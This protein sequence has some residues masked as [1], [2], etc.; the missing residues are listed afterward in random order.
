M[1]GAGHMVRF[2]PRDQQFYDYFRE[3]AENALEVAGSLSD[4]LLD[5]VDAPS[6][7]R[8]IEELEH[9]GDDISHRL[10]AALNVT[11]LTPLDRG[12]ILDL[13][14]KL[15]DF[16]DL[17]TAAAVR[18]RLYNIEQPTEHAQLLGRIIAEQGIAVC[19]AISRLGND[20]Q[21]REI[22]TY[23]VEINRLE[24]EADDA[25]NRALAGLYDGAVSIPDVVN[26]MRWDELYRRLEDAAD[27]GEDLANTIEAILRK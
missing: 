4:L 21:H 16:V 11:F 9:H 12:D 27:R 10:L 17:I 24:D 3:A 13:T 5:Y 8:R 6:K 7:I 15:D 2:L 1:E 23:T 20:R 18:L 25:F 14:N 19:E 22:L 26:A